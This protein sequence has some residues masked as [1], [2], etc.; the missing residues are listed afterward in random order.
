MREIKIKVCGL[1]DPS[2][3]EEVAGLH[4]QFMGFILYKDSPRYV[5]LKKAG[6]LVKNLPA[7]ILKVGVLVNEPLENALEIVQSGVF[8]LLQLHGTESII[9]CQ[10]LSREIEI[11]KAFP[12]G[13]TLPEN[14]AD[15]QSFCTMFLFDNAGRKFGG[16]GKMFNHNILSGYTLNKG[17]ILSG[18]ISPDDSGYIASMHTN[19]MI[20]VDLNSR[21]EISPGIKD[22]SL[23]KKFIEK[24]R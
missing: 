8:D 17:F 2:N 5:S 4:P 23:L 24:L 16:T 9:Y 20:G 10:K 15:Y 7:S 1:K 14:L 11:I 21:F 19:K 6:E 13:K 3:I 12:I 18:G 22:I